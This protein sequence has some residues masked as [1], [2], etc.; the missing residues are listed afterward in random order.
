MFYW[1]NVDDSKYTQSSIPGRFFLDTVLYLDHDT[2]T[3][4]K[5]MFVRLIICIVLVDEL[6]NVTMNCVPMLYA[7]VTQHIVGLCRLAHS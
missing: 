7:Y 2:I 4:E 3:D 1:F 5:V 6:H